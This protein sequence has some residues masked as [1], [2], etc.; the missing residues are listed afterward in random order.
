MELYL[1]ACSKAANVAATKTATSGLA[2]DSQQCG[3]V[4]ASEDWSSLSSTRPPAGWA[5]WWGAGGRCRG[6]SRAVRVVRN[7]PASRALMRRSRW[8]GSDGT[9]RNWPWRRREGAG[10]PEA[11][12]AHK[13]HFPGVGAAQLLDLPLGV[14]LPVIPGSNPLYYTTKLSEKLFRPSYGFNLTDPYCRLLENQYKSLH[15]PH[16]R[17]YHKRKD[18]LRRLKK[19]GYI[20]SNNRIVCTLRELNKYRQYLTSLKLDFERNYIREQKMLAKQVNKLQEDNQIPGRSDVAQFQNWLLQEGTPSIK[21]QERLIRHRYLD[22]VSRELERLER[23]AEEQRLIRMDREERRQ[24]EHT[25]RK[26]SLRR[27][28]EEEWK[29]KEMLLLTR[30]GEDVKREARIEEQRRKS[31]EESDRKVG[32]DIISYSPKKKKKSN[33]DIKIVYPVGDQKANKGAYGP[34]VNTIHRSLSSSKNVA[35]KSVPSVVCQPDVQ[36]NDI[37]QKYQKI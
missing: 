15:D 11:E 28:I 2:A 36:D 4:S 20:T 16:L 6:R 37:E 18:I 1:S 34:F 29:A 31:R 23:T 19:G 32:F 24:Q 12:G 22:M 17:A 13:T 10:N 9:G 27:K 30:I 5:W 26:L 7:R 14:K 35:K 3:D 25:R 33:D 8:R 21:D